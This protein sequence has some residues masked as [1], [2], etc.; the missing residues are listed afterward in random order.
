MRKT[1]GGHESNPWPEVVGPCYTNK[2]L[3]RELGLDMET[4]WEE[5]QQLRILRINTSDQVSVFPAFQVQN[6]KVVPGLEQVLRELVEGTTS[7][8]MWAQWLN[9]PRKRPDGKTRRRI[10][11]L[12]DGHIAPLVEEARHDAAAWRGDK[13]RTSRNKRMR[14]VLSLYTTKR[15]RDATEEQR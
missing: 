8:L 6:H 11:E 12:A 15:E 2:S 1:D 10:D 3:Q 7:T 5:V 9:R 13:P 14:E 4:I